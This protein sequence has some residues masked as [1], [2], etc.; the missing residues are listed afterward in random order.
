MSPCVRCHGVI[1]SIGV[2]PT[3]V[4]ARATMELSHYLLFILGVALYSTLL[5]NLPPFFFLCVCVCVLSAIT[6]IGFRWRRGAGTWRIWT[7]LKR[8][9]GRAGW[10]RRCWSNDES[11]AFEPFRNGAECQTIYRVVSSS[12]AAH[13]WKLYV[14]GREICAVRKTR[15]FYSLLSMY[16]LLQFQILA[17]SKKI[18]LENYYKNMQ[19]NMLT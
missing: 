15:H 1:L 3:I 8:T 19:I 16:I 5:I 6:Y 4:C 18:K 10:C 12:P 9:R 17:T 11:D 7:K 2:Y 13:T 14:R